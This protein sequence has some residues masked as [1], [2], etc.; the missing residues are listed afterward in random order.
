MVPACI[1][2]R[3]RAQWRLAFLP[4]CT[5]KL[6]FRVPGLLLV[7][8]LLAAPA[9]ADDAIAATENDSTLK[10]KWELGIAGAV[11]TEPDYPASDRYRIRPVGFPYF[12]Y[13]GNFFR[14]D[15]NGPRV[16]AQ[17]QHDVELTVSG[18][19]SFGSHSSGSGPRAGMPKLDYLFEMGPNLRITALRFSPDDTLRLDLPLRA[20]FTLNGLHSSYEGLTFE[21]LLG[22]HTDRFLGT[23]WSG[24]A[25]AGPEWATGRFQR[26][27]YQVDAQYALPDRPAYAAHG[28]YLGSRIEAGAAHKLGRDFHIFLFGRVDNYAGAENEDSP[29]YKTRFGYTGLVGLSW[30]FARSDEKVQVPKD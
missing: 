7:L 16:R 25:G 23:R 10:P 15:E 9:R 28:G 19:A 29:L 14:S 27:F 21:P 30:T 4:F 2:C 24:Y 26:Y 13:R 18:N 20:V 6:P 5:V 3:E 8:A 12:I 1:A 17:L 11:G 22:L